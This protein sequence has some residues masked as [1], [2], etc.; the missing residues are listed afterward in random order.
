M[1]KKFRPQGSRFIVTYN[2]WIKLR[3]QGSVVWVVL[4]C[5]GW[6]EFIELRELV[7]LLICCDT[8][9]LQEGSRKR[10]CCQW[11]H[12]CQSQLMYREVITSRSSD[13]AFTEEIACIGNIAEQ[14][15]GELN[16]LQ[17]QC[18]PMD[19]FQSL[20][21]SCNLTMFP[22]STVNPL[23]C[24]FTDSIHSW[25]NLFFVSSHHRLTFFLCFFKLGY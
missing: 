18:T 23:Q 6:N 21:K 5:M 1:L 9:V 22:K 16:R 10:Y 7:D 4:C 20:P 24:T 17:I 13:A 19:F 15:I 14:L 25:H 12:H 11:V 3:C 2:E 8:L